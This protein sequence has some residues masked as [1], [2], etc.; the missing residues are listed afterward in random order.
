M[1]HSFFFK[2]Y[3]TWTLLKLL[4]WMEV[5]IILNITWPEQSQIQLSDTQSLCRFKALLRWWIEQGE[6]EHSVHLTETFGWTKRGRKVITEWR[7]WTGRQRGA[8]E[9][10]KLD[11]KSSGYP[12]YNSRGETGRTMWVC[13]YLHVH[14]PRLHL[15]WHSFYHCLCFKSAA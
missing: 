12:L 9:L 5:L 8:R 13:V 14:E 1:N 6:T 7:E 4:S 11:M 3:C 15:S 10:W 2:S